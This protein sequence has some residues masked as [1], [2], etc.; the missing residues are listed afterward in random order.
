VNWL[1]AS[2]VGRHCLANYPFVSNK[3][4]VMLLRWV[5][6]MVKGGVQLRLKWASCFPL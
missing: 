2:A 4:S 3:F 1:Y 5:P 6:L